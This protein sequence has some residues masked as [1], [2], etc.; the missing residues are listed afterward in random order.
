MSDNQENQLAFSV[1]KRRA[2][3]VWVYNLKNLKILRQFGFIQYVSRRLKYVVIYMDEDEI[4]ANEKKIQKLHFV[5][6]I[7][8]SYRPDIEMNFAEKI[9]TKA[10]YKQ[11][12]DLFE[13]EEVKTEIVLID[14]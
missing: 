3:V 6:M 5:R 1:T 11:E 14:S 7:Q 13:V 9:G 8:H 4:E 12:I 2:L 10:A